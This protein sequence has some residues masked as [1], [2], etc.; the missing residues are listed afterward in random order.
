MTSEFFS[1]M[2]DDKPVR[3]EKKRIL[4]IQPYTGGTRIIMEASHTSE[5][6]L[7]YFTP[8]EYEAVMRSYLG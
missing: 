7:I 2:I 6:P 3:F 5:E 4:E 1:V 8:D